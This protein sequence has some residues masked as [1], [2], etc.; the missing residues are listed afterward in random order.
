MSDDKLKGARDQAKAQYDCI[1]EMVMRLRA[2]DDDSTYE[3][4]AEDLAKEAGFSVV[5]SARGWAWCAKDGTPDDGRYDDEADAWR[6]C[7]NDNGLRP[8]MDEARERISEDALSVEVR[9]GWVSTGEQLKPDEFC[10]LLCTGG[11]AVRIIGDLNDHCE[12][13][14][15][16]L[17]CQDWFTPWTEAMAGVD[18]DVLLDY[19]RVFYFGE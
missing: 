14:T 7:C 18:G 15:A 17:E 12:P 3:D 19:C 13:C 8:D 5:H 10:I 4:I 1:Y 9:S 16:K 2:A 6:W 11:P